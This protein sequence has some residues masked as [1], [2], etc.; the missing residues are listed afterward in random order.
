MVIIYRIL[1][2]ELEMY[3][4]IDD[5]IALIKISVRVDSSFGI[6]SVNDDK[7]TCRK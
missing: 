1:C 5:Y 6:S 3:S 2:K 4:F 7:F